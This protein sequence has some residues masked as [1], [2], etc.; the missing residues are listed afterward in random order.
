MNTDSWRAVRGISFDP[1]HY[2]PPVEKNP[3]NRLRWW[4]G[5]LGLFALALAYTYARMKCG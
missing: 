5:A 2:V 4:L 1:E 3:H